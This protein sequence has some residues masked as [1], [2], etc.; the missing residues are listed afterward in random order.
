MKKLFYFTC[1]FILYSSL[2]AEFQNLEDPK[3]FAAEISSETLKQL[4]TILKDR[5]DQIDHHIE[6]HT[7]NLNDIMHSTTKTVDEKITTLKE[8]AQQTID[9]TTDEITSHLYK[10]SLYTVISGT[11]C[12][13]GGIVTIFGIQDIRAGKNS[14][15]AAEVGTGLTALAAAGITGHI[16]LSPKS[17]SHET[18]ATK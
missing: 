15:G 8:A 16:L 5:L 10:K 4:D 12:I 2:S 3:P 18:S 7:K 9:Q 14:L 13:I 17:K 11:I 6:K 1:L